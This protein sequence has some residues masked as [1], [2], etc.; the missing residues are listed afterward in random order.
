MLGWM[1][2]SAAI[3]PARRL[4]T[5][6][7]HGGWLRAFAT[8]STNV[9]MKSRRWGDPG[10]TSAMSVAMVSVTTD[11]SGTEAITVSSLIS[12]SVDALSFDC[13]L[14]HTSTTYWPSAA[15]PGKVNV[16]SP[17]SAAASSET[18]ATSCPCPT[19]RATTLPGTPMASHA[20]VWVRPA[21]HTCGPCDATGETMVTDPHHVLPSLGA[22]VPSGQGVHTDAVST[23]VK[24]LTGHLRH[25]S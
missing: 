14:A 12:M 20:T 3:E 2:T 10:G 25:G 7:S 6:M 23:S 5:S 18:R 15:L 19:T 13:C 24:L 4:D 16:T 17:T 1:V 8:S 11:G 9:S 21:P 22:E